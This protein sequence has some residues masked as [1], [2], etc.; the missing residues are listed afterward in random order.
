MSR[1][2]WMVAFTVFFFLG[3]QLPPERMPVKALPEDSPPLPYPELLT[4]ARLQVSTATEAFYLDRWP[5]LVAAARGLE[6]TAR[7]FPKAIEVPEK[8]KA[9]LA[10]RATDLGAQATK[11]REAAEAKDVKQT[12]EILQQVNLQVRELRPED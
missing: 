6:Q 12:T 1:A 9:T 2:G 3:C 8:R 5:D 11:L 4:R 10:S 7:F